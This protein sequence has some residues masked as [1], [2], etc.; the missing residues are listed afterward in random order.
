MDPFDHCSLRPWSIDSQV[1][2]RHGPGHRHW[3]EIADSKNERNWTVW[4]ICDGGEDDEK[5]L[6]AKI[7]REDALLQGCKG[8]HG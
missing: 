7:N 1:Q 2:C 4:W 3:D 8:G 6:Y 5:G